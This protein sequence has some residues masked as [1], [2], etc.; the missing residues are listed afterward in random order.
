MSHISTCGRACPGE[1]QC[2][3]TFLNGYGHPGQMARPEAWAAFFGVP[4]NEWASPA[5]YLAGI[6]KIR[7]SV[8]RQATLRPCNE[9]SGEF[10]AK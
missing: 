5:G 1:P 8:V 4:L 9:A 2:S 7:G 10:D 6:N 3:I